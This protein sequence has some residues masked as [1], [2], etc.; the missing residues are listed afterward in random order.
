MIRGCPFN[1]HKELIELR[2][3]QGK[4]NELLSVPKEKLE[5]FNEVMNG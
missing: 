4:L 3:Q 1:F 2:R 5:K